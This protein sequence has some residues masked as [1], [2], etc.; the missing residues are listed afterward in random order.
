[1][2]PGSLC[3]PFRP[4][5]RPLHPE[6]REDL[7]LRLATRDP[8]RREVG[9]LGD[10]SSAAG[11]GRALRGARSACPGH[12]FRHVQGASGVPLGGGGWP[13]SG[14][15]GE[16]SAVGSLLVEGMWGWERRRSGF[17]TESV[18]GESVELCAVFL[19][20]GRNVVGVLY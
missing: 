11:I 19:Q 5:S 14:S 7:T 9:E 4:V 12:H 17:C 2:M 3:V 15:A 18:I 20:L 8:F 10:A 6:R 16:V 1:M 13:V